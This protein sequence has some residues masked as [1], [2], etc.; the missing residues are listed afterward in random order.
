MAN[1]G[2]FEKFPR[3][4]PGT[5]KNFRPGTRKWP[6][7]FQSP[8]PKTE[9]FSKSRPLGLPCK[10]GWTI[11]D[12]EDIKRCKIN[13]FLRIF[14]SP[15]PPI[16]CWMICMRKK[17]Q[18]VI[19][20]RSFRIPKKRKKSRS[21][22]FSIFEKKKRTRKKSQSGKSRT[23]SN[24]FFFKFFKASRFLTLFQIKIYEVQNFP[25]WFFISYKNVIFLIFFR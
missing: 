25:D 12:Q 22:I 4:I 7:I 18:E 6:K 20:T 24:F 16:Q 13:I 10:H 19:K 14:S 15:T 17:E 8:Q 3:R 2:D 23:L 1:A 11:G 5:L 9:I 21:P